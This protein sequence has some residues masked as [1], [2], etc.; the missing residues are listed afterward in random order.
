MCNKLAKTA[1]LNT[2]WSTDPSHAHTPARAKGGL[3]VLKTLPLTRW[4][5]VT[6]RQCGSTGFTPVFSI[7]NC[8]RKAGAYCP[9]HLIAGFKL[10]HGFQAST[11]LQWDQLWVNVSPYGQINWPG[12]L[13]L[14]HIVLYYSWYCSLKTV[15]RDW[16][17]PVDE[18]QPMWDNRVCS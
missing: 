5:P 14:T 4:P 3:K 10:Q 11:P 16:C 1:A 9:G 2:W 17:L 7:T 13:M 8:S 12:P 6:S 15:E 18:I